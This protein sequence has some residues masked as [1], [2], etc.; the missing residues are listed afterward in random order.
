VFHSA[1]LDDCVLL[2]DIAGVH[3]PAA[4]QLLAMNDVER[5]R[6]PPYCPHLSSIEPTFADYKAKVRDPAFGHPDRPDR[7]LHVL[8]W[9][10]VPPAAIRGNCHEALRKSLRHLPELTG[11]GGPLEGVFCSIPVVRTV[12]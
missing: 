10:S 5:M 4:D 3:I 1:H 7:M 9:A 2:D 8:A 12:P 6:L 11:P